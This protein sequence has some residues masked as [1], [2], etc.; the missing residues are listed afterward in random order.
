MI[1]AMS[2][3]KSSGTQTRRVDATYHKPRQHHPM[4]PLS[5]RTALVRRAGSTL[6]FC[7]VPLL[8][9]LQRTTA[10]TGPVVAQHVRRSFL[11]QQ[12]PRISA[13]SGRGDHRYDQGRLP[14]GAAGSN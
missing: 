14:L 3:G 13:P 8:C 7:A 6:F 1:K 12:P 9:L 4:V 2:Q 11:R 10:W 5:S